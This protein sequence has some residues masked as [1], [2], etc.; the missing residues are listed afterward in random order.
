MKHL[1]T[2]ENGEMVAVWLRAEKEVTLKRFYREA[3][4]VRLQPANIQMGPIHVNPENVQIQGKVI[5]VIRRL[6]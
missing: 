5:G 2:A 1:N 4:R 6:D 3:N